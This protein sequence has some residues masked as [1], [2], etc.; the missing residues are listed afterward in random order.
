MERLGIVVQLFRIPKK[1]VEERGARFGDGGKTLFY[2][3]NTS[4]CERTGLN[5]CSGWIPDIPFFFPFLFPAFPHPDASG[6]GSFAGSRHFGVAAQLVC[7]EGER[8]LYVWPLVICRTGGF[9]KGL[10]AQFCF[11]VWAPSMTHM[12][13]PQRMFPSILPYQ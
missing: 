3:T 10:S 9:S 2:G 5:H 7:F 6:I 4:P 13:L 1:H 11:I 12:L 8:N